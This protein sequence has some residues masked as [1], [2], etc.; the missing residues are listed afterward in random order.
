MSKIPV[1]RRL[2][3]SKSMGF[4]I[5]PSK[6]VSMYDSRSRSTREAETAKMGMWFVDVDVEVDDKGR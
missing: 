1:N 2:R 6:P 5:H 3:L 4:R